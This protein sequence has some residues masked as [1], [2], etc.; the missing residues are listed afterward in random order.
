MYL[1]K[2]LDIDVRH[3]EREEHHYA[4][5][6]VTSPSL[7]SVAMSTD[8]K[9]NLG[10]IGGERG[11]IIHNAASAGRKQLGELKASKPDLFV[12]KRRTSSGTSRSSTD[13]AYRKSQIT[14]ARGSAAN[15]DVKM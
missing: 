7:L 10:R 14:A 1:S 6:D 15:V 3:E 13:A 9:S 2:D 5:Q 12:C 11:S 4:G 8:H